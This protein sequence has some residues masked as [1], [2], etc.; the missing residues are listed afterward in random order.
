MIAVGAATS[1]L[2]KSV[3]N[4]VERQ[5]TCYV[6]RVYVRNAA[7]DASLVRERRVQIVKDKGSIYCVTEVI[8]MIVAWVVQS[9]AKT[10]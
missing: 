5:S 2:E 1:A 4:V 10:A 9:A 3:Q 8:V 7:M 6:T